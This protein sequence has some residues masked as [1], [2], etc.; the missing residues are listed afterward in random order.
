MG[1]IR[2]EMVL[3][4]K[5]SGPACP[6]ALSCIHKVVGALTFYMGGTKP[7]YIK[8]LVDRHKKSV[9]LIRKILLS[10]VLIKLTANIR[11]K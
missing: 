9:T 5:R 7:L 8:L 4:N 10:W 1:R 2:R 6:I 11:Y 3:E